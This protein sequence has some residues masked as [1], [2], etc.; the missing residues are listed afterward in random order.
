MGGGLLTPASARSCQ[1]GPG[2]GRNP[3]DCAGGGAGLTEILTAQ[4]VAAQLLV[5][6]APR[7][8][9]GLH[10][11][12]DFALVAGNHRSTVSKPELGEAIAYS[13]EG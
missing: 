9:E 11:P 5:E 12:A 1:C 2:C 13:L 6:G 3:A 7:Q 10:D 8:L 4:A